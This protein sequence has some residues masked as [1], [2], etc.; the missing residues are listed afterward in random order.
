MSRLKTLTLIGLLKLI[1]KSSRLPGLLIFCFLFT[2]CENE[3]APTVQWFID[4]PSEIYR[5]LRSCNHSTR[6]DPMPPYTWCAN[7]QFASQT[8]S[9]RL[10]RLEEEKNLARAVNTP[11]NLKTIQWY[12]GNRHA[13]RAKLKECKISIEK[14]E[15]E[16]YQGCFNATRAGMNQYARGG[17]DAFNGETMSELTR[18]LRAVTPRPPPLPPALR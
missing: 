6:F 10:A 2:G 9:M 11:E 15:I 7:A 3:K 17:A 5:T 16:F 14:G 12:E 1:G 13:R 18:I 4:N 8:I